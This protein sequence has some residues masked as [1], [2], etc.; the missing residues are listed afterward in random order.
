M[1]SNYC[2]HSLDIFIIGLE[3]Y[4]LSEYLIVKQDKDKEK[5]VY[6]AGCQDAIAELSYIVECLKSQAKIDK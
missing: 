4:Y 2:T 3:E 1:Q 6:F 5:M